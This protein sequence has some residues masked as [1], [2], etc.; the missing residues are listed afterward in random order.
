MSNAPLTTFTHYL[1]GR[2]VNSENAGGDATKWSALYNAIVQTNTSSPIYSSTNTRVTIQDVGNA[3][4]QTTAPSFAILPRTPLVLT[5]IAARLTGPATTTVTSTQ[6][7]G[8]SKRVRPVIR[9]KTWNQT[10]IKEERP[11]YEIIFAATNTI[12]YL[13]PNTATN[14][15]GTWETAPAP[16][17]A[18]Y[19]DVVWEFLYFDGSD[20]VD[21][22]MSDLQY[23]PYLATGGN[24]ADGLAIVRW[25]DK[26]TA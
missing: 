17:N 7:V 25:F 11:P 15:A 4:I 9:W 24:G 2:T 20:I 22:D 6:F 16:A 13:G 23:F 5:G 19:F 1:A 14:A 26:T 3:R 8:L 12:T 18:Y 10:L 21:V